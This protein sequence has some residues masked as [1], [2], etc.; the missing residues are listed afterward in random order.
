M[1]E[2][3]ST[4]AE[5]TALLSDKKIPAGER[6]IFALDV[7]DVAEAKRLIQELG[8]A[9]TFYKLGLELF[10]GG[11]HQEL[12]HH[13]TERGK[14]IMMDYKIFDIPRT[15]TAAMK[16]L[17]GTAVE[18]V[19]VH[20]NDP[21][22]EAALKA[23]NG[24]KILAVTVLTSLQRED[25]VA[26]GYPSTVDVE[27]L[28]YSRAKRVLEMG[29]DGVIS[30][31]LEAP[32][33]R[34]GLGESFIIVVPGIRPVENREDDQKRTVSLEEAF[35]KGA[36]YVVVGR[37]IRNSEDPKATAEEFQGRIAAVFA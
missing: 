13:L 21:V 2:T 5:A 14:K 15:V 11:G 23:K 35:Q 1:I 18:F 31:G 25:L 3:L 24:V 12:V 28:V 37:P 16:Q 8:D 36:D 7:A 27:K 30:S 17:H 10:M 9:V 34:E 4:P 32:K 26:M 29:C 33:L 22:V 6:L 20:G 19:T